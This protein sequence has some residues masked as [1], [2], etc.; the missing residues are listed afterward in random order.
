AQY[1]VIENALRHAEKQ[2][3]DA[4]R[5]AVAALQARA[6][7]VATRNPDAWDRTPHGAEEIRG[8]GRGNR[9]LAFPYTKLH[10]SQWN[11]DQAAGL[12]FCSLETA[13][14][15]GLR[16]ERFVYP[17]AVADS[18]HMLP[19]AARA[20]L[21]QVPGFACAGRRAFAHAGLAA[22]AL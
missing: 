3:L 16:D 8:P 1:A 15:L 22:A 11:V 14:G 18:N 20:A 7:A 2:T 9:M 5:D 19:L 12:I 10:T 17:L 4:H 13:R 21:E 6:S